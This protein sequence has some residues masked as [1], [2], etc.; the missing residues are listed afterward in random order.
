[1]LDSCPTVSFGDAQERPEEF[2]ISLLMAVLSSIQILDFLLMLCLSGTKRNVFRFLI[3]YLIPVLIASNILKP[4]LKGPRPELSCTDKYGMPSGH[5]TAAGIIFITVMIF[6]RQK[7]LAS[8]K[9]PLLYGIMMPMQ[10]YSRIYLHY[11][12]VEQVI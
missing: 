11:H 12:T 3:I 4:L 1:M 7:I 2:L 5:S 10:A 9:I 6:Y 8:V